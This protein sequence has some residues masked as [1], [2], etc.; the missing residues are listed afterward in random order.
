MADHRIFDF[1]G[2]SIHRELAVTAAVNGL[3]IA[4]QPSRFDRTP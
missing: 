3:R 4:L 2:L 1:S